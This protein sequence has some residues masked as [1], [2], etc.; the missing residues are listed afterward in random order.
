MLALLTSAIPVI[1]YAGTLIALQLGPNPFIGFRISKE[2]DDPARWRDLHTALLPLLRRQLWLCLSL[3]PLTTA[4]LLPPGVYATTLLICI[5]VMLAAVANSIRY[6]F[7][8]LRR[9]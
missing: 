6:G 7:D 8:M 4:V 9:Q 3:I 5:G 1:T 2:L